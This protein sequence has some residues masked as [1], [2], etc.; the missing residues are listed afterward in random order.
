MQIVLVDYDSMFVPGLEQFP[1]EIKGLQGYQHKGRWHNKYASEKADYFSELV[2]Y[3]SLRAL[4]EDNSWWTKLNMENSETLL[5]NADD[6]KSCGTSPIFQE[7]SNNIHLANLV[8]KLCEFM[9]R[10]SIEELEP[11]ENVTSS[12]IDRIS[13][14]WKDGNGY[15]GGM[16]NPTNLAKKIRW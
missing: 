16:F 8:S 10:D 4:A 2:I 11:L 15:R 1:D 5:F 7:L 6:I 14:G 12:L 13:G 3:L 9:R